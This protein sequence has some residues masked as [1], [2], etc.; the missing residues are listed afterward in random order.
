[1]AVKSIKYV[2]KYVYKEDDCAKLKFSNNK[3]SELNHDEIISFY[4]DVMLVQL[5]QLGEYL[6]MRFQTHAVICLDI[7]LPNQQTVLLKE[8]KESKAIADPKMTKLESFFNMCNS[9]ENA[10]KLL[11][12]EV[13]PNCVWENITKTGKNESV[14]LKKTIVTRL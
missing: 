2:Y 8:G 7:L 10:R 14:E 5:K 1:M 4:A 9:H 12:T 3:T 11:Y 6:R 13:P